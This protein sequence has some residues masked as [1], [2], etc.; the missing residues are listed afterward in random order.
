MKELI[1]HIEDSDYEILKRQAEASKM[2]PE[3]YE[4]KNLQRTLHSSHEV[5]QDFDAIIEY[6]V[7]K[8]AELYKRLA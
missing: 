1:L 8:N 5:T 4:A 6:V 7:A 3:E 2:T